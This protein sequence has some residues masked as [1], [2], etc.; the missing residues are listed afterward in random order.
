VCDTIRSEHKKIFLVGH[1][2]RQGGIS[3]RCSTVALSSINIG[4]DE[5]TSNSHVATY[6][7][8]IKIISSLWCLS[9]NTDGYFGDCV[10]RTRLRPNTRN[11]R[12]F[13][14]TEYSYR[15]VLR[16]V[17]AMILHFVACR[18]CVRQHNKRFTL[19][20]RH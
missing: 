8:H 15:L 5:R 19:G 11:H 18:G 6:R 4:R 13:E 20:N 17:S 16:R 1:L 12:L 7:E 10:G 3:S 2:L 14:T 9:F